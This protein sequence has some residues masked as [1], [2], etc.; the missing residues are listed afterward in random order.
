MASGSWH[1]V[2]LLTVERR[3]P[4]LSLALALFG[5]PGHLPHWGTAAGPMV[6]NVTASTPED[7]DVSVALSGS[8]TGSLTY[9]IVTPPTHGE[10]LLSRSRVTYD[11]DENYHGTDTFEYN[12]RDGTGAT[13]G[14]ATA[15]ITIS[16][17]ND[18]PTAEPQE[19]SA[20]TSTATAITLLAA[21]VD[22]DAITCTQTLAPAHG[23]VR[24]AGCIAT[25]TSTLSYTGPDAFNYTVSDGVL[26]SPA[27]TVS[28]TV[29]APNRA[30]TATAGSFTTLEDTAYAV[31]LAGTDPDGDALTYAVSTAP[32]H[33]VVDL[34]GAVATYTP[35][36]NYAGTDNFRFT[37][38]DSRGLTSPAATVAAT[39]TAVNDAPVAV[40]L[41][42]TLEEDASAL[43]S[44]SA[45]DPD[46]RT[47]LVYSVAS[48]PSHGT[49]SSAGY[50]VVNYRPDPDYAGADS[51]TYQVSDGVNLSNIATVSL[52]LNA[53]DDPPRAVNAGGATVV[54]RPVT[55]SADAYDPEDSPFTPT[56]V[57]LPT[58]GTVVASGD[59]FIYTPD[60]GFFGAD[61]FTYYVTDDTGL[62]SSVASVRVNVHPTPIPGRADMP[63]FGLNQI[64]VGLDAEPGEPFS[65]ASVQYRPDTIYDTFD[66]LGIQTFRQLQYADLVWSNIEPSY[67]NFADN[68]PTSIFTTAEIEPIATLFEIQY[69]S[70]TPPWCTDPADFQKYMGRD[71][72]EYLDHLI[73][74]YGDYVRYYEIGNEVYHWVASYPPQLDS[75]LESM[76]TCFPAEGYYPDE[77]GIFLEE[78]SLY[79]RTGD[80]DAVITLPAVNASDDLSNSW[81]SEVIGATADIEWFDVVAYHSYVEW[82]RLY[83]MRPA[84]RTLTDALG[85]G[86]KMIKMT[87]GG[88]SSNPEKTKKTDYPNSEET[89]ASDI[90]RMPLIT[91]GYGDATFVWHALIPPPPDEDGG[92]YSCEVLNSDGTWR[93]SAY[94]V[95]LMTSNLI[96]FTQV[97]DL[98]APSE[99]QYVYRITRED[100]DVRWVMWGEQRTRVPAGVSEWTSVFPD[101]DGNFTW[102]S[103]AP[104]EYLSL[105]QTPILLR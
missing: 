14:T 70:P 4:F 48:L 49:L 90:F 51:F 42:A 29:S 20:T 3:V 34:V 52:T 19:V 6:V 77:Q 50:G 53:A 87:E 41:A 85:I 82:T 12:V 21:D 105:E 93:P 58:N 71:A 44:Y 88:S 39:I 94:T 103:V 91:W 7:T 72:Y 36:T 92:G 68:G 13:S 64:F 73:D 16:S 30:P 23:S 54:D 98:S 45:T 17:V 11:P 62:T 55:L 75:A 96:P 24:L 25:Y 28:I 10:A 79:I 56:L 8:G 83:T 104:G 101:L 5:W 59:S 22:G 63:Q 2:G 67:L 102:S 57:G 43:V 69:A 80:P 46:A 15:T 26:T 81:L 84:L 27:A 60:P 35:T 99:D 38:T 9:S 74:Y 18:A 78:A 1:H 86:H 31:T 65:T 66:A 76:P 97:S 32:L 89:Q 95:Q 47:P 33:G 61:T 37:V 100:G 40:D